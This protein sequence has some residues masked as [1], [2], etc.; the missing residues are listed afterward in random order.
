MVVADRRGEHS[1]GRNAAPR[2]SYRNMRGRR[3]C[4]PIAAAAL[5]GAAAVV[6]A[7]A[8]GSATSASFTASDFEWSANGNARST[9]LTIAPGGTVTFSYPSGHSEH[10]ADFGRGP[11][12]TSCAQTAGIPVGKA[13]PLPHGPS[14]AGWSG[15]CT[16]SAPVVYAFHS[17]STVH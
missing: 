5:A 7:L 10:N 8:A 11:K 4:L 3:L 9:R 15:S 14:S 16:F 1:L 2:T 6:P 13:P 12:P 17:T